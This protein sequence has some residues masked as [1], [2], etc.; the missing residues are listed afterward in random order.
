MLIEASED[1]VVVMCTN[2]LGEFLHVG[3]TLKYFR[4]S[5]VPIL[6]DVSENH[7][8][9]CTCTY[10]AFSYLTIR[11]VQTLANWRSYYQAVEPRSTKNTEVYGPSVTHQK[12]P[13]LL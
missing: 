11:Y 4:R 6:W 7:E 5:S 12:T 8:E 1:V 13:F 3:G 10:V 2:G 9:P